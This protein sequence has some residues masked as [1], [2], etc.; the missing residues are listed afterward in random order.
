MLSLGEEDEDESV[1]H[2]GE[3]DEDEVEETHNSHML[4]GSDDM[5]RLPNLQDSDDDELMALED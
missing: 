3:C 1:E 2:E 5:N 4:G